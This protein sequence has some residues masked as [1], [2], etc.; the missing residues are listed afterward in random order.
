[1]GGHPFVIRVYGI[2]IDPEKGVFV[3]DEFIHGKA[4]TKFPGGGMN[5]GEGTVECLLREMMEET[6]QEFVVDEHVYTTD[7]FVRSAFDEN[8]QVVSVY[9]LMKPAGDLKVKIAET[10]FDFA[11][12]INEAQSFRFIPLNKISAEDFTLPIDRK[13]AELIV[14]RFHRPDQP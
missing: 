11:E 6:Q 4:Y 7:F 3:S 10:V 9:Y 8:A 2:F 12:S 14:W 5:F 13:V 1:M